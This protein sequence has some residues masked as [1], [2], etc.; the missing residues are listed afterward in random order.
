M[1]PTIG[2]DRGVRH[3]R[4]RRTLVHG[5]GVIAAVV[6][7]SSCYLLSQGA[8]L[9]RNQL[10]AEPIDEILASGTFADGRPVDERTRDVLSETERIRDYAAREGLEVSANYTTLVPTDRDHLVDV[11]NATD[12]LSFARHEWWWPFVGRLPYKG[13]YDPDAARRLADRF[14]RR[15]FDVWVRPVD[16]FSTLG[17]F[18]DPLYEFMTTYDRHTIANL[19]I[20]ESA[21]ATVF[22]RGHPQFN[23]EFATF[24]GNIGADS[25]LRWVGASAD[26]VQL[27]EDRAADRATVRRLVLGLR[28][29]LAAIYRSGQDDDH[30]RKAKAAALESFQ[31]RLVREYDTLFRTDAYRGLATIPINNAF[32]DL[33]VSYTA[34]LGLFDALY[35]ALGDDLHALVST[36]RIV[37]APRTIADADMR[38]L[39]R[40]NPKNYLA[41]LVDSLESPSVE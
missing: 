21:H 7:L 10:S 3:R 29:E 32:I 8:A 26:E 15:G 19:I 33:Y 27:V 2:R 37:D 25:Y 36:V 1:R 20:H 38:R 39:A 4:V 40:A 24:V 28:D 9:V 5:I 35:H 30:M 16:A 22:L 11:V 23:E 12:E 17:I 41:R 13:F 6:P 31:T 18:R 34:D 14:R